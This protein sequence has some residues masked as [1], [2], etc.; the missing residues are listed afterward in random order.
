YGAMGSARADGFAL[1]SYTTPGDTTAATTINIGHISS[2]VGNLGHGNVS[3]DI[4][5]SGLN[6]EQIASILP[7]LRTHR[8]E[9]VAAGAD[10]PSLDDRLDKL[11]KA[12]ASPRPD[13]SL[14]RG[15]LTDLRNCLSGAAGSLVAAGALNILN[16]MLGTGVPAP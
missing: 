11:E 8:H 10:G 13:H 5:V 4:T 7:Q 15:L 14:L 12:L 2:L 3:G 6:T 16:T 1:P 9:L